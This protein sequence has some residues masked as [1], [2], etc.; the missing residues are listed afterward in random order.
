MTSALQ[1]KIPLQDLHIQLLLDLRPGGIV[2]IKSSLSPLGTE[3]VIMHPLRQ[4]QSRKE[5]IALH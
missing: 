5:A 1:I 2:L 3:G 4:S